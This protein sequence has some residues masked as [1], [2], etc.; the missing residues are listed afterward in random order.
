MGSY[1]TMRTLEPELQ[2]Q[3]F[4][5]I[6]GNGQLCN[7]NHG[8]SHDYK[9]VIGSLW[10]MTVLI[11]LENNIFFYTSGLKSLKQSRKF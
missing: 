3:S 2:N 9:N 7:L 5:S 11:K 10:D 4:K 6:R 8:K 1:S